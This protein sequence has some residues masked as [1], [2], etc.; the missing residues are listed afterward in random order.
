MNNSSFGKL[1]LR[2][3]VNG[4]VVAFLTASL[5]GL[6]TILDSGVLPDLSQLKAAG[7]SGLVAALAYLLKNLVTNSNGK[8]GV[9]ENEA[10]PE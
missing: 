6:I 3:L 1:N 10:K 5:T 9:G 8:M 7:L 4:L 2:D